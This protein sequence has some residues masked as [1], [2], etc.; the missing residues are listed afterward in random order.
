MKSIFFTGTTVLGQM[1]L[2]CL[3]ILLL[4]KI[5]L[6]IFKIELFP[7]AILYP[8]LHVCRHGTVLKFWHENCKLIFLAILILFFC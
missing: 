1:Q 7:L 4:F 2:V 5:K 6:N 8:Y 3:L